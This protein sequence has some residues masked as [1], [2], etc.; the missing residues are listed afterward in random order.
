MKTKE[1]PAMQ[2]QDGSYASA[3]ATQCD[4]P[5]RNSKNTVSLLYHRLRWDSPVALLPRWSPADQDIELEPFLAHFA[6]QP[7][8]D[9][10]IS[11]ETTHQIPRVAGGLSVALARSFKIIDPNLV[12]PSSGDWERAFRLFDLLM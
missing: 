2:L 11:D 6:A 9:V 4:G 5:G 7:Q 10:S 1:S 8:L 12:N 3:S